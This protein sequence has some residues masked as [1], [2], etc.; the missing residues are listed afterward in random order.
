MTAVAKKAHVWPKEPH[1]WYVEP[2]DC[3]R[4]LLTVERF[5]GGA[6]DPCCGRGNIVRT[7]IDCGVCAIGTDVVQ[8]AHEPWFRGTFDYLAP[9]LPDGMPLY[10]NVVSN[11]PFFR[12]NGALTFIERALDRATAKVAVFVELRFIA[13]EKRS[14]GLFARTPPHRIWVVAPRPSCP[15]GHYLDAGNKAA[16]G[17]PDYCWLVWD[18]TAPPAVRPVVGWVRRPSAL[19]GGR[20]G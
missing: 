3:T 12:G 13:G 1:G 20:D 17:S 9:G 2:E 14:L 19:R 7:L 11:P 6:H 18:L 8:R 10:A 15:P 16:G 5:V 4:A